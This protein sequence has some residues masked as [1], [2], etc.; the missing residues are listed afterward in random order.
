MSTTTLVDILMPQL[1]ESVAEGA[2]V[3]W[4]KNVGDLVERDEPLVEVSS[5][6]V[7]VEVPSPYAGVLQEILVEAEETV[8][9]GTP[10]ARME[11][12]GDFA[13]VGGQQAAAVAPPAQP[14]PARP[15]TATETSTRDDGGRFYSPQVRRVARDAGLRAGELAAIEGSGRDG[16]VTAADVLAY[17][18]ARASSGEPARRAASPSAA[19]DRR[20]PMTRMRRAIADH[21]TRSAHTAPH[22]T[23]VSEADVT[24]VVA[25]R[26][27]RHDAFR[28]R[29]GFELTYTPFFAQAIA[30]SLR[31]HPRMNSELDGDTI[32]EKA[33]INI[34]IAVAIED[35]L[36]VPVVRRAD[37]LTLSDLAAAVHDVS[38]RARTAKLRPADLSGGTFTITNHGVFGGLWATPIIHQ[39]QA[40]II[41]T[42]SIKRRPVVRDDA[43]VIR[44]MIYLSLSYDHR[45]I[46]GAIAEQFLADLVLRLEAI[47][48]D[49]PLDG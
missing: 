26:E 9:T 48:A 40:A 32:I 15:A 3:V 42:G 8:P 2:V 31:R 28:Q 7:D 4:L 45:V 21:M 23:S 14:S 6:K 43:I 47:N 35:G 27:S 36:L 12:T 5:D 22:V 44:S 20:I 37:Q 39:P 33:D 16:R 41:A 38:S 19:G 10:I 30:Q 46:D 18:E 17:A 34:G 29:H 11:V 13:S 24:G 49:T 1:G 25:C